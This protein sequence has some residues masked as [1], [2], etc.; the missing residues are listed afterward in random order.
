MSI[1]L[2]LI[3]SSNRKK[4]IYGLIYLKEREIQGM[5]ELIV[6][7]IIPDLSGDDLL[8]D[9]T[10]EDKFYMKGSYIQSIYYKLSDLI[11]QIYPTRNSGNNAHLYNITVPFFTLVKHTE[12]N[13]ESMPPMSPELRGR[14]KPFRFRFID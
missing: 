3:E 5:G 6:R 7:K 10:E 4:E 8:I 9:P 2:D 1:F 11:D 12:R 14:L 13:L